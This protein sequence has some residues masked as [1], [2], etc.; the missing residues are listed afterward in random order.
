MVGRVLLKRETPPVKLKIVPGEKVK[1]LLDPTRPKRKDEF[2]CGEIINSK[3]DLKYDCGKEETSAEFQSLMLKGK[4][5]RET[6]QR[7]ASVSVTDEK[8]AL[9]FSTEF[10][11]DKIKFQLCVA[12]IPVVVTSH[13]SQKV[14]A[15]ASINWANAGES[16][17]DQ[18]HLTWGQVSL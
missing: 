16:F 15:L 10:T 9:I 6:T 13:D 1:T 18:K 11:L 4:I 5:K 8:F 14:K 2:S 3:K 17:D 7:N 12:S